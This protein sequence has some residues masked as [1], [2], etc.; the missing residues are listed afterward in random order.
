MEF[1]IVILQCNRVEAR[2]DFKQK[3][4]YEHTIETPAK[5]LYLLRGFTFLYGVP[6]EALVEPPHQ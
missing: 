2:A 6:V 3:G 1:V 5:D 4:S